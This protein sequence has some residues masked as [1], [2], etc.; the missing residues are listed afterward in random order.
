M[1]DRLEKYLAGERSD[2]LNSQSYADLDEVARTDIARRRK[3]FKPSTVR[4]RTAGSRRRRTSVARAPASPGWTRRQLIAAW[5]VA[6]VLV[7]AVLGLYFLHRENQ[8]LPRAELALSE[9][10]EA[11]DANAYAR[12][13]VQLQAGT[14]AVSLEKHRLSVR[15]DDAI[16]HQQAW[17]RAGS[18]INHLYLQMRKPAHLRLQA[19]SVHLQKRTPQRIAIRLKGALQEVITHALPQ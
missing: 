18:D 10:R 6:A 2:I 3:E 4:R 8:A 14:L 11:L 9:A 19:I 13:A 17:K 15:E 7:M 12:A 1:R 16:V 5:S